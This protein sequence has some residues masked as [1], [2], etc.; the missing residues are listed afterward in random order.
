MVELV[1]KDEVYAV[2]GAALEVYWQLGN[3]FLEPIYQ[4]ALAIELGRRGI[5][6]EAK[7]RLTVRYKG[8]CLEKKYEA[9]FVCYGQ[10]IVELKSLV[11]LS[12]RDLSQLVNYMKATGLRV[13]LLINFGSSVKLEWKRFII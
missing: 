3:G 13:G 7:K 8:Q 4:E 12:G 6:F 9:D 5:P 10:I 2:V 1:L 11:G